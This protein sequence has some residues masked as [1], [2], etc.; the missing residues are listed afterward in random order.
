MQVR[1]DHQKFDQN[2]HELLLFNDTLITVS[3]DWA[4]ENAYKKYEKIKW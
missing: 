1:W 2:M 3:L 4:N